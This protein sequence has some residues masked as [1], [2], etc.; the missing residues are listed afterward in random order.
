MFFPTKQYVK[1]IVL[2][3]VF[4]SVSNS[5]Y[6]EA[7]LLLCY[8]M[9]LRVCATAVRA[10]YNKCGSV[11]RE[12]SELSSQGTCGDFLLNSEIL[13]CEREDT[14][15]LFAYAMRNAPSKCVPLLVPFRI[16]RM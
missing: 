15:R 10:L 2:Y 11:G 14:V 3:Y 8:E 4:S 9:F 6:G 16:F 12:M 5:L 1:Q 13:V 7:Y